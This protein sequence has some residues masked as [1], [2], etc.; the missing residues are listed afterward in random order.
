MP[1]PTGR[2]HQSR[3]THPRVYT[4]EPGAP[5]YIRSGREGASTLSP[6]LRRAQGTGY[7][8]GVHQLFAQGWGLAGEAED[9]PA[10]A[11]GPGTP[12]HLR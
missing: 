9:V 12:S 1:S 4:P 10:A 7:Q 11:R 2:G 8:A 3:R 6:P 5:D